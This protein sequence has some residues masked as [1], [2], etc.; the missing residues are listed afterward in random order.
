MFH[1]IVAFISGVTIDVLATLV[2]HFTNKNKS[3]LASTFNAA[4]SAC[5]IY[6]FVD[7]NKDN[8]IAVPYL[9]GI[10][11]GGVVGMAMKKRLENVE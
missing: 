7:I 10:W 8:R 9:I 6:T 5:F 1:S 11:V 3:L 4:L 2:F